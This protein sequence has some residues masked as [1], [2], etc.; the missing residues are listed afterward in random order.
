MFDSVQHP[1]VQPTRLSSAGKT[2]ERYTIKPGKSP[3]QLL[4]TIRRSILHCM[5]NLHRELIPT[6]HNRLS[7]FPTTN[8]SSCFHVIGYKARFLFPP[9]LVWCRRSVTRRVWSTENKHQ[10]KIRI[11]S[12]NSTILVK[13]G[14]FGQN[15]F[16]TTLGLESILFCPLRSERRREQGRMGCVYTKEPPNADPLLRGR[17][18]PS[19]TSTTTSRCY[20]T[21]SESTL[22]V[23]I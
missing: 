5:K 12:Q 19:S 20:R 9:G 4:L 1:K 16:L 23:Q 17:P 11:E 6:H 8:R 21:D 22:K 7:A 10:T 14:K 18:S 13:S 2:T 3:L 15:T